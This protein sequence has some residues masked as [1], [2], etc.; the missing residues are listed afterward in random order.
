MEMRRHPSDPSR[1]NLAAF[2]H[3]FLESIRIF[4]VDGFGGNVDATARHDPVCPSEIR[5]AFGSFRFHYLL[6]LSMKGASAQKR[7]VFFLLQAAGC[8]E[9]LFVTRADVTGCWFPFRFRLRALK[10]N[11]FPRHDS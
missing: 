11:D 3:E 4:V 7:I 1:Q 2:S 8:I 10:S 9:A 5:S 6:N